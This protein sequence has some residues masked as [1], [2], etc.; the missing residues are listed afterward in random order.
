MIELNTEECKQ[1]IR[2][3]V[4]FLK[5]ENPENLRVFKFVNGKELEVINKLEL[6]GAW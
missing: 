3:M 4:I 6:W 1:F 5:G 2:E